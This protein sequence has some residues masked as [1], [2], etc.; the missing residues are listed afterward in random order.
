M[1]S[2][3]PDEKIA[4]AFQKALDKPGLIKNDDTALIFYDLTFLEERI[5]NLVALFPPN[6]LHAVAIKANPLV[7]VLKKLYRMD[8]GLEAATLPELYLAEKTGFSPNRIVYDSPC[9]TVEEL[10]YALRL[11]VHLNADSLAEL[12]R[13]DAV[14]TKTERKGSVGIRINPQVGTGTIATT[15]V[16]DEYSK[17]GVP[18]KE[19]RQALIDAFVKFDWLNGVHLHIGSQGCPVEMLIAGVEIALDFIR[20][21]HQVFAWKGIQRRINIFD[22]GGGLPVSYQR[23]IAPVPMAVY[24]DAL[25]RR[26]GELF[27]GEFKLITEFGRYLHANTGWTVSRV[28]Y[29]KPGAE[30][31][32][33]MIHVGADLFIRKCYQPEYWNHEITVFDRNGQLKTGKDSQ[34]YV[35]AGPLCFAGDMIARGIELPEVE[36]GDYVLIHD[37]GAYTLSMWSRYNSRQIPKV[38]G[39]F[40]D[41]AS[42]EILRERESLSDLFEF[43]Q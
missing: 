21:V 15:S 33:L 16:A 2:R 35:I 27:S 4:H 8:V 13:I 28:E 10:E 26:C 17:F 29:V 30:L 20:E 38:I 19:N 23:E 34:K 6:T 25:Q 9:K 37:T 14:L 42:I 18:L 3:L 39:Y 5:R 7:S 32:T 1:R 41:G 22:M 24:R 12:D 43:W 11:G 40:D 36:V 31:K